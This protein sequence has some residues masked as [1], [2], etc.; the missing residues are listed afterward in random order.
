MFNKNQFICN[1][2][3][4]KAKKKSCGPTKPMRTAWTVVVHAGHK[5]GLMYVTFI[6][7]VK[8]A[9]TS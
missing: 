2:A 7:Y 9:S 8:Y 3:G 5:H 1:G 6:F 4:G